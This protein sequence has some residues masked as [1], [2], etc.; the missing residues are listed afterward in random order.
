MVTPQLLDIQANPTSSTGLVDIN[1]VLMAQALSVS[2]M[3]MHLFQNML[4]TPIQKRL[5]NPNMTVNPNNSPAID[6]GKDYP[7][8]DHFFETI[9]DKVS[10]RDLG[11]ILSK[12]TDAGIYRILELHWFSEADLK[13]AGLVLGDIKW[14]Q[15]EVR[16]AMRELHTS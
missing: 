9:Q 13:D 2:Q 14:L 10:D 4:S 6:D 15:R 8:F 11:R 16:K 3:Q 1:S 5:S 7:R 12:L